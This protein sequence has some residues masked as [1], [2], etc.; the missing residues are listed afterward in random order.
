M[1]V[2]DLKGF[3]SASM[4]L[5]FFKRRNPPRKVKDGGRFLLQW[6]CAFSSAEMAQRR[7]RGNRFAKLQWGCAFS[8]AEIKS[9]GFS[10]IDRNSASMGLRFFK[11]RNFL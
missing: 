6:G 8:S 5:R 1:I 10:F 7:G 2:T 3:Q 11:R 9:D 4:G